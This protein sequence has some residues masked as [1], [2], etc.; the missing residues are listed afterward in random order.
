MS[1]GGAASV[2]YEDRT[3]NRDWWATEAPSDRDVAQAIAG[4]RVDVLLTHETVDGGTHQV[5]RIL[6]SNPKDGVGRHSPT[7]QN[8]GDA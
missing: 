2:D 7:P 3:E 6:R 1:F 8:P 5:E 4:G